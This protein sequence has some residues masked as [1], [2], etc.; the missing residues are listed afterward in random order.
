MKEFS[1]QGEIPASKSMMNRALLVK[2][3]SPQVE[4]VGDSNCDDVRHMKMSLRSLQSGE[5]LDCGEAGTVLRFMA[6]RVSRE[7][8]SFTLRGSPRLFRRPQEDL[9]DLL[10]QLSVQ[11]DFF[12]DRMVIQGLGWRKPARPLQVGREV[13]SQF[14]TALLLNSWNLPFDLEFE[15][16]AGVS[17][18]YWQMSLDLA[19]HFGMQVSQTGNHWH[20]PQGQIVIS[21]VVK[22]EPDYSS[23][24]A[25]AAA[26]A[27]RGQAEILNYTEKSS[28]PDHR[29][30]EL[31]KE[32]GASF[33]INGHRLQ[34]RKAEK[35]RALTANL[36]SSPDLFPVLATVCAFAEGDSI[37]SGAPHLI[38]KESD[39]IQKTAELLRRAGFQVD[40]QK[41]GMKIHGQP[42]I[43]TV[44]EFE[45]DPENDHRMAM[46]AAL[47]KLK[48]FAVRILSPQVVN[49]SFPEFWQ[50]IGVQ[51]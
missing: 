31:L 4:I 2:S 46:A 26:A 41:D 35:L 34:V 22:M 20:I 13:S 48:G 10:R 23:A 28:Q 36:E 5:E 43:S 25:I 42:E 6:M 19:K 51:P 44:P 15:M 24:F 45:F 29:F 49:K 16:N 18:G 21:R 27:L 33:L 11:V 8:G 50:A 39:R 7:K 3:Y 9:L 14:A 17:E 47:L 32:M 12:S 1:Y 30:V 37:L 38:H 40:V